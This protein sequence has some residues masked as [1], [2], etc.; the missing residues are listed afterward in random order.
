MSVAPLQVPSRTQDP[1]SVHRTAIIGGGASGVL[2]AIQLLSSSDN[3]HLRVEIHEASGI[4]GRG[5]AYGTN[6]PHHL[7]NVRSR[8]MSAFADVPSDLIDWA[9]ATGRSQDPQAFLPR[10]DFATYLQDRLASVAD[11]R[12][13]IR[14]GRVDDVVP[15]TDRHGAGFDIHAQDVVTHADS[16]VLAYGNRRPQPLVIDGDALPAAPWHL[17]DPWNLAGLRML[18]DDATIVVVGTGLTAVDTVITLLE[19]GP[20]RRVVMVSRHGLLPHQH[21]AQLST[22]WVQPVP[23]GPLTADLLAEHVT[24]QVAAAAAQGVGWRA[25]VDGLRAATPSLWK[26]LPIEERRR[27]LAVHAREWETRRHRM[28]PEVAERIRAY[29]D[30][31]RLSVL[32]GGLLSIADRGATCQVRIAGVATPLVAGA[33]VNC[34]GPSTDITRSDDPLLLALR[35]R[36]LVRPDP[37]L[38]GIDTTDEG[39]LVG[40]DGTVAPGLFAVGPPR[41]GTLWESTAIPEIR[42]QAADVARGILGLTGAR[43]VDTAAA[44]A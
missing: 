9:R 6:D 4:V 32:G 8:H 23:E 12:L 15:H 18:P 26:R 20:G 2:T 44:P 31:G 19:E 43:R 35:E 40:D 34:T 36:G 29:A 1:R 38:L 17:A 33:V 42:G 28:A 7:L 13:S 3:P 39:R 16:V 25:V 37:L 27:F 11:Y 24:E 21:V 10:L 5:I 22:A 14:A 30:D 41:K